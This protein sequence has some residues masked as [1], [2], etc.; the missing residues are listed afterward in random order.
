MFGILAILLVILMIVLLLLFTIWL[1]GKLYKVH[2]YRVICLVLS[3]LTIKIWGMVR[4][5]I[6]SFKYILDKQYNLMIRL[7]LME[8]LCKWFDM[9]KRFILELWE[10]SEKKD[11]KDNHLKYEKSE[12]LRIVAFLDIFV[13]GLI[14]NCYW[15][16]YEKEEYDLLVI[17]TLMA[18]LTFEALMFLVKFTEFGN[19]KIYYFDSMLEKE[20]FI[21]C[22]YDEKYCLGGNV[23]KMGECVEYYMISYEAIQEERLYPVS[24]REYENLQV[25]YQR[26]V[27][28]TSNEEF[29]LDSIIEQINNELKSKNVSQRKQDTAN[30]FINTSD[31]KVYYVMSDEVSGA[32]DL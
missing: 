24:K 9:L 5:Q 6:S 25:N 31:R 20:V 11:D 13:M 2:L 32:V 1:H 17:S 4:R 10:S 23:P 29:R 22:R 3:R 21:F 30:I 16:V 12:I 8:I 28:Q 7:K 18:I 14:L 27:M 15:A 26:V 19:A